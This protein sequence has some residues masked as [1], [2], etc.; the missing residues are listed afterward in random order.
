[1]TT[2]ADIELRAKQYAEAREHLADI[3]AAMNDGIEAI[4]RDN[5]K[6]LKKA[7]NEAAAHHDALKE[8]I[9]AAPELFTKPK[10]VTFHGLRLGYMKGKGGIVWDDADAV[11]Q[12]IQKHLPDQAEALIRWSGKPL[13]EAINQLDVATLK[14]IG[15][16]VVDTGEQVFI[17]PVDGAVEKMVDALLKDATADEVAA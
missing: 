10:T 6:K 7:I 9:E 17:K 4:K 16:R 2:L 8:L 1:M 3:V 15:C 5:M 14:K 11:V 12:A 13:K